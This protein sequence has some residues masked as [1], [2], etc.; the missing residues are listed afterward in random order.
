MQQN[1]RSSDQRLLVEA[2]ARMAHYDPKESL[3]HQEMMDALGITPEDLVSIDLVTEFEFEQ[4]E[5]E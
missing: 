2:L 1:E 5:G 4:G 3:T